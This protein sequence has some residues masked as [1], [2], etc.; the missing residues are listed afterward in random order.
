MRAAAALVVAL[1]PAFP[2]SAEETGGCGKFKW[3]IEADMTLIASAGRVAS[4]ET[5]DASGPR[6][7][8]VEMVEAEKADFVVA[9]EKPFPPGAPAGTLKFEA[10][11]GLYQF[12]TTDRLWIDL[13]QDGKALPGAGFSGVLDCDGARKSVRFELKDGPALIQFSGSPARTTAI[14]ITRDPA[15]AS[16]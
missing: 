13:V 6:A 10:K 8:R 9:P 7:W 15:G 12:T 5:V 11:A 4:G 14:S 16:R 1:L 3:P 2:A